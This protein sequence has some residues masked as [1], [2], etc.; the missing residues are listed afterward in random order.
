MRRAPKPPVALSEPAGPIPADS[1]IEGWD[2]V[3]R[4]QARIKRMMAW[5]DSLPADLRQVANGLPLPM[6]DLLSAIEA[7]CTTQEETEEWWRS[8]VGRTVLE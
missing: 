8:I 1:S 7:G 3:E 4:R 2:V 5:H 6:Q